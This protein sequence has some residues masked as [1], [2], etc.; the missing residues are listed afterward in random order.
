M[1]FLALAFLAV[2]TALTTTEGPLHCVRDCL[3]MKDTPMNWDMM[4][5]KEKVWA[6]CENT[7]G[8]KL[9]ENR[10]QSITGAETPCVNGR[11]GAFECDNIDMLAFISHRD[12][13]GS[14][15]TRGN[16]MWGG[17]TRSRAASTPSSA[18]PTAPHSLM[19]PTP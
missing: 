18:R 2:A 14:A 4:A 17:S 15:Q 12:M 7:V 9:C 3:E 8:N 6:D 1:K 16:D 19:S 11:A 5:Q 13:T 10:F